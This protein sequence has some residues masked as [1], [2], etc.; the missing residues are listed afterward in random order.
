[1]IA[2]IYDT[3]HNFVGKLYSWI[4]GSES[5]DLLPIDFSW[6]SGLGAGDY[7]VEIGFSNTTE[8]SLVY[9]GQYSPYTIRALED[10]VPRLPNQEIPPRTYTG[11]DP[12]IYYLSHSQYATSTPLY[13]SLSG[14]IAPMIDTIG[15]NLQFFSYKFSLT[16][17]QLLGTNIGT[18]IQT[19][20]GYAT[21][22]NQLFGTLPIVE[23]FGFYLAL[24]ILVSVFR[25]I[26]SL[27]N[28][29]KI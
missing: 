19:A 25:I 7:S 8:G 24:L 28:L 12:N 13:N 26:R 16:N 3:N 9:T 21:N 15:Q 5:G 2:N 6:N 27:I 23:I 29:I 11:T 22:L 20:N 14:S 1:V 4:A 18:A 10:L 17:A